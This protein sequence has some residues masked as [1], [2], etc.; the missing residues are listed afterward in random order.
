MRKSVSRSLRVKAAAWAPGPRR[1]FRPAMLRF[2]STADTSPKK[3]TGE[4]PFWTT[5]RVLLLSTFSGSIAYVLGATNAGNRVE[6]PR[7]SDSAV[8]VYGTT[9]DLERVSHPPDSAT[10]EV[11]CRAPPRRD[12][13]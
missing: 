10:N 1:P 9:K 4:R 6:Q 2:A 3:H 13:L 7:P 12:S 5:G 8:P 11:L